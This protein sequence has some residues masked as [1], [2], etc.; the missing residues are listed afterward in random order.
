MSAVLEDLLND[1]SNETYQVT[2]LGVSN[3]DL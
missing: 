3:Y 2:N 1:E